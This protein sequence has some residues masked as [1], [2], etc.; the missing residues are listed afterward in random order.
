MA[1]V[2]FLIAATF[3]MCAT[4]VVLGYGIGQPI[5]VLVMGVLAVAAERESIRLKPGLEVLTS[6][7]RVIGNDPEISLFDT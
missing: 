6:I 7:V 1:W 4:F 3:V 2:G 5:A